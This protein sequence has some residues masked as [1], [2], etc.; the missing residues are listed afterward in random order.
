MKFIIF[1]K[2]CDSIY[3]RVIILLIITFMKM[4]NNFKYYS[5][6]DSLSIIKGNILIMIHF[7]TNC[8]IYIIMK[9]K[10]VTNN[11]YESKNRKIWIHFSKLVIQKM[12]L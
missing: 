11:T 1:H 6:D 9:K 3:I 7:L 4:N 5:I 12:F 10:K 2:I 8:L